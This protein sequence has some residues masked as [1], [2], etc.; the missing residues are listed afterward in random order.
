LQPEVDGQDHQAGSQEEPGSRAQGIGGAGLQPMFAMELTSVRQL[1][2]IERFDF[3]SLV[4][5]GSLA[6]DE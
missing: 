6:V 5:P 3:F 1:I 2:R 4:P